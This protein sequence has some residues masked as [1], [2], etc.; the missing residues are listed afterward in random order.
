MRLK[1]ISHVEPLYLVSSDLNY[2]RTGTFL[3]KNKPKDVLNL[4][5]SFRDLLKV[6]LS[7]EVR[8]K[9]KG[10]NLVICS[11]ARSLVIL[12]WLAGNRNILLDAGWPLSDSVNSKTF[13]QRLKAKKIFCLDFLSFQLSKGVV[14]ESD[15]QLMRSAKRFL[16]KRNKCYRIYTGFD[17][18]KSLS[19]LNLD[20]QSSQK[21]K[22]FFRGKMNAEAGEEK[23]Y[24]ISFQINN[25]AQMIVY[26]NK[27]EFPD[28]FHPATETRV[29]N[30]PFA[31]IESAYIESA[32][33]LG[34]LGNSPRLEWTI[35]HKIFEA[36]YY[37]K[38]IIAVRNKGLCELFSDEEIL[39]I[40]NNSESAILSALD[41]LLKNDQ[42]RRK[43]STNIKLKYDSQIKQTILE[44][45]FSN[46]VNKIFS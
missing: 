46:L 14:F 44:N 18:T 6:I 25:L 37:G 34:Q 23:L 31:E 1:P 8:H 24:L 28:N 17:E 40:D 41:L 2:S 9:I 29:G 20:Y 11:P 38:P 30:L 43:F 13:K 33:V 32:V 36:A 4:P 45:Q 21:L 26:S 35:P 15:T 27:I 7:W 39:Y 16:I 3:G 10:R 22:V 19:N 42:L 12:C 5:N